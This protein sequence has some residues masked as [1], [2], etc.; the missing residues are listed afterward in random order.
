MCVSVCAQ[1]L[2]PVWLFWILWTVAHQAP[3]S[4]G[5]SRQEYWV[6][7]HFLLQGIFLTQGSNLHLLHLWHWLEDFLPLSHF[8]RP[9]NLGISPKTWAGWERRWKQEVPRRKPS[10]TVGV[11]RSLICPSLDPE[12]GWNGLEVKTTESPKYSQGKRLAGWEGRSSS[13]KLQGENKCEEGAWLLV[14]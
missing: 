8:G 10:S 1:S 7:C 12:K 13:L 4:M 11:W 2:S 3:L 14:R 5:F 6:D 9:N